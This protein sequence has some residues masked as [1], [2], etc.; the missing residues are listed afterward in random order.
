ML[1]N[2]FSSDLDIPKSKISPS[3]ST[4]V[5]P[6]VATKPLFSRALTRIAIVLGRLGSPDIKID[7][8]CTCGS[9]VTDV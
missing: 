9:L 3:A 4:M 5:G 8:L 7:T 2:E 6:Q 1:R